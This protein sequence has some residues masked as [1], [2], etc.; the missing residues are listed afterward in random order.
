M[1]LNC[2]LIV[3]VIRILVSETVAAGAKYRG[4]HVPQLAFQRSGR[5]YNLHYLSQAH[6][7]NYSSDLPVSYLPLRTENLIL[8]QVLFFRRLLFNCRPLLYHWEANE[9]TRKGLHEPCASAEP[10]E[11]HLLN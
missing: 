1:L 7:Q 5:E 9:I 8:I 10:I 3:T 2:V 6:G 11:I 4:K